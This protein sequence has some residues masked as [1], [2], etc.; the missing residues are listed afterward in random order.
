VILILLLISRVGFAARKDQ[1]Q[2]QDQE[3]EVR[4]EAQVAI[5]SIYG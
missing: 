5:R 1:E 4:D 2:D 3:Q